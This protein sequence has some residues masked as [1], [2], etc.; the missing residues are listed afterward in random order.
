MKKDK[1]ECNALAVEDDASNDVAYCLCLQNC[2]G[3]FLG[4]I[5]KIG[6]YRVPT[7]N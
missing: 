1:N 2:E 7:V 3:Y 5:I 4:W 6:G